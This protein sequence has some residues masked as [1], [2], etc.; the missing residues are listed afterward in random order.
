MYVFLDD[1]GELS[2]LQV[3]KKSNVNIPYSKHTHM[4]V[5]TVYISP[6]QSLPGK[7]DQRDFPD[8]ED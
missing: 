4:N 3:V 5:K 2:I 1:Y 6:E 7:D 8:M